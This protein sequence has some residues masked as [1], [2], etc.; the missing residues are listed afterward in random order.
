[1]TDVIRIDIGV[2]SAILIVHGKAGVACGFTLRYLSCGTGTFFERWLTNIHNI[3]HI[4]SGDRFIDERIVSVID[5]KDRVLVFLNN[6]IVPAVIDT[7]SYKV[8]Y[9]TFDVLF[10]DRLIL[11]FEI[12]SKS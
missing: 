11:R 9:L 4:G 8:D 3:F 12:V 2:I 10:D 6:G 1:L 5:G 7:K